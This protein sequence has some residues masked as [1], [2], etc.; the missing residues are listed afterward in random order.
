MPAILMAEFKSQIRFFVQAVVVVLVFAL[1]RQI[2][3]LT[4]KL[5]WMPVFA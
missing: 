2:H 1:L 3:W 5:L 4:G